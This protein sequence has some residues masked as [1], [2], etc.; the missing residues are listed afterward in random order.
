MDRRNEYVAAE[1]A[2]E[3]K[4][5]YES[6][7]EIWMRY[8]LKKKKNNNTTTNRTEEAA[9]AAAAAG[10]KW[11]SCHILNRLRIAVLAVPALRA[12]NGIVRAVF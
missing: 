3:D 5:E 7:E 1:R 12:K 9:S 6:H 11:F 2:A 8:E 4:R 10:W